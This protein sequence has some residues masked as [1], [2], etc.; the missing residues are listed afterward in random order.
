MLS[1]LEEK[2]GEAEANLGMAMPRRESIHGW[3][4]SSYLGGGRVK[5]GRQLSL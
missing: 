5:I 4:L 3:G 1:D 2:L